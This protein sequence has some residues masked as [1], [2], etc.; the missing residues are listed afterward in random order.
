MRTSILAIRAKRRR[1]IEVE[2]FG[3]TG[4]RMRFLPGSFHSKQRS[5]I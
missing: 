1:K 2:H 5:R 3:C 4:Y